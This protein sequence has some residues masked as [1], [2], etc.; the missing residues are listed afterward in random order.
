M[1]S[2]GTA[3]RADPLQNAGQA[4]P[5]LVSGLL[6]TLQSPWRLRWS[7]C[8]WNILTGWLTTR[9]GSGCNSRSRSKVGHQ[10]RYLRTTL[11]SQSGPRHTKYAPNPSA[12]LPK[13]D[14]EVA[15]LC[16]YRM[17]EAYPIYLGLEPTNSSTLITPF[18]PTG[19]DDRWNCSRFGHQLLGE[20]R[21]VGN[22]R[23]RQQPS[24][25]EGDFQG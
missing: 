21:E 11:R 23:C 2:P 5:L 18:S 3:I 13:P 9:R 22:D 25:A 14:S 19:P 1:A 20:A 16:S 4:S 24:R 15:C 10:Q 6:V 12:K 17:L 8:S 7:N